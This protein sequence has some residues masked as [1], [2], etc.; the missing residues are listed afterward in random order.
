VHKVRQGFKETFVALRHPNFRLWFFGQMFSLMGTWMQATA[1]GYLVY[2]LTR[3]PAYL[4]YVG[5]VTGVPSWFLTL[6]AGSLADRLPRRTLIIIF[7]SLMMAL[8]FIL[9]GLTFTH[10]VQPWHILILALL[11]GICTAF[12]APTRQAFILEM[13]ADRQDMTNA[14]ALNGMLFNAAIVV[15]PAV[16]GLLYAWAGPSWCFLSNGL[17]FLAVIGALALMRIDTVPVPP[18]TNIAQDMLDGFRYVRDHATIRMLLFN[19]GVFSM[20]GFG[21]VTLIPAW[22]VKVLGGDV[23]TNGMLLSMRGVGALF[24]GVTVAAQARRSARGKL[25]TLASFVFPLTMLAFSFAR[26]LPLSLLLMAGMG[27]CLI[28]VNNNTNTLIQSA[29]DDAMRGRVM[30]FF[31]LVLFGA[32]PI[33]S[34]VSGRLAQSFGEPAT[35]RMFASVLFAFA[36]FVWVRMPELRRLP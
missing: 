6:Y 24:G 25:W 30:G 9:A 28:S 29:C 5:F 18:R 36:A 27:W 7:Q 3:S 12:D 15:G 13:V 17:S 19:I 14:V 35:A 33:G 4:G 32:G 26:S 8:A 1:Q 20:L 31:V 2:D 16:A 23:K 34:L 21:L 22:A 11:L 10:L